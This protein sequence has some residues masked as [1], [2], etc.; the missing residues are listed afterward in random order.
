MA[1][2]VTIGSGFK[3][4]LLDSA[5]TISYF[6]ADDILRYGLRSHNEIAT[7][8]PS[9]M[10]YGTY[11]ASNSAEPFSIVPVTWSSGRKS[12]FSFC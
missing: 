6:T 4:R 12:L 11:Y 5:S 3:E 10:A 7:L 1:V 2:E 9:A 8:L